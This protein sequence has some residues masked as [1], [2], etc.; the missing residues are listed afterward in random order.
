MKDEVLLKLSLARQYIHHANF[1]GTPRQAIADAYSAVNSIIS[2]LLLHDGIDPPFNHK[3]KFD[4]A[5]KKCPK[6]FEPER[7]KRKNWSSFSPGAD[8]GS[9]EAFYK[10][11]LAS[12]Y[13]FFSMNAMAASNRVQEASSA[14][15]AAVRFLAKKDGID[16]RE[17]EMKISKLA[18]GY[19][20]S[21]ISVAVGGAHDHLF[22]EAEVAGEM[23]GSK[24]GVKLAAT[25]NYCA[26]DIIAGDKL[27]QSIL[28]ED[29]EIAIEAAT[30]YR[31]FIELV[32][33]IDSKRLEHISGGKPHKDCTQEEFNEAPD[34]M[35]AMKA[36]YHGGT[37]EDMGKRWGKA[38][39]T[40]LS[41]IG[42]KEV[43]E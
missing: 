24:L 23:C 37:V 35:L 21:E 9:L 8:W 17:L 1:A 36:R 18:F 38:I 29:K 16:H 10:E 28:K 12:R 22:Y 13:E 40:V 2:A 41:M 39:G 25:T 4:L 34:F 31:K 30:I 6:A 26:L 7:T 3:S 33:K 19:D 11:W 43:S 15:S 42:S 5:H 32:D 14:I 27:T 20:F